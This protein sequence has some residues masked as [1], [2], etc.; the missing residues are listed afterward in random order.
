MFQKNDIIRTIGIDTDYIETTDFD[1]TEKDKDFLVQVIQILWF[2]CLHSAKRPFFFIKS[3][4]PVSVLR[5][6]I[7]TSVTL[8][9]VVHNVIALKYT[10]DVNI[11]CDIY[12]YVILDS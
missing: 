12:S 1:I 9:S 7:C 5:I 11:L 3:S 2:Q 6:S 10:I 8:V 4:R